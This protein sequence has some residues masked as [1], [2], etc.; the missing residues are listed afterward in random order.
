MNGSEPAFARPAHGSN[1][2]SKAQ[3]GLTKREVLVKDFVAALLSREQVN[4]IDVI[5]R[6]AVATA[7]AVI[8]ALKE[9][10]E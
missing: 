1:F 3:T 9:D 10:E 6:V 4:E 8:N 7:D 2:A 5:V